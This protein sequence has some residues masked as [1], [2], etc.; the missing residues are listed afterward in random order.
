VFELI[1]VIFTISRFSAAP[2]SFIADTN[3]FLIKLIIISTLALIIGTY[4]FSCVLLN[5]HNIKK[6]FNQ[7]LQTLN[8]IIFYVL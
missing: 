5:M 8:I 6:L 3:Q 7:K 1:I 4:I 2:Y